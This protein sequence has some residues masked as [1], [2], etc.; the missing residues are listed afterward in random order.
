MNRDRNARPEGTISFQTPPNLATGGDLG[1][2]ND[3]ASMYLV[4]LINQY[5]TH[6]VDCRVEANVL[7]T[8]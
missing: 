6:I 1:A 8:S 5:A 7:E 2:G 4:D 3:V